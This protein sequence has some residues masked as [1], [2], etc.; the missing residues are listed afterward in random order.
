M[1][2]YRFIIGPNPYECR[3]ERNTEGNGHWATE[4][5]SLDKALEIIFGSLSFPGEATGRWCSTFI[6]E[7]SVTGLRDDEVVQVWTDKPEAVRKIKVILDRVEYIPHAGDGEDLGVIAEIPVYEI[8]KWMHPEKKLLAYHPSGGEAQKQLSEI[9]V[10]VSQF[11]GNRIAMQMAVQDKRLD[12]QVAKWSMDE[13]ESELNAQ[14][15]ALQRKLFLADT[16]MHGSRGIV[17]LMKGQ[18]GTGPYHIFQERQFLNKEISLLAN[19]T[20]FDFKQFSQ[21]DKW[22]KTSGKMFKLLPF[23]RTILVTRVRDK[24]KEYGCPWTN[25]FENELNFLSVIWV[26]DGQNVWRMPTNLDFQNAVFPDTHE[27]ARLT[28]YVAEYVYN[29]CFN[30]KDRYSSMFTSGDEKTEPGALKKKASEE[31]EP[32]KVRWKGPRNH[33]T[34]EDWKASDDYTTKIQ[35]EI[36]Q[37][38]GKFLTEHNAERMT[39]VLL[40]QGMVDNT[41]LLDIPKGT[42]LFD[43]KSS[44]VF[45]NLVKDYSH[46]LPDGHTRDLLAAAFRIDQVRIGDLLLVQ[47]GKWNKGKCDRVLYEWRFYRIVNRKDGHPLAIHHYPGKRWPHDPVKKPTLLPLTEEVPF[48]RL[49]LTKSLVER[50]LD[51]REWKENNPKLVPIFAQWDYIQ[52]QAAVA[53]NFTMMRLKAPSGE[54]YGEFGE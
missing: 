6:P 49:A 37:A 46:G 25:I 2:T 31:R 17:H 7:V 43:W 44:N 21:L 5:E 53:D 8:H 4:A 22:L 19:L 30:P 47:G 24:R 20:N 9:G 15:S 23:E 42:N 13:Q 1:R 32:Y 40:L 28:D 10:T 27:D 11:L 33:S 12:M 36:A 41:D 35:V 16:Y 45:F 18:R 51:D 54:D 52:E 48:I 14:M 38:A 29:D 26:R 3:Q 50:A 34:L 39:F